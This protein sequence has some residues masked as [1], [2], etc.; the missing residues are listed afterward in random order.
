[1]LTIKVNFGDEDESGA[2]EM[3]AEPDG[4]DFVRSG[5]HDCLKT[6]VGELETELSTSQVVIGDLLHECDKPRQLHTGSQPG[7]ASTNDSDTWYDTYERIADQMDATG[8]AT[9]YP[10]ID[11][12][13]S[14]SPEKPSFSS[15]VDTSVDN[16]LVLV[17]PK[18]HKSYNALRLPSAKLGDNGSE[19]A[20]VSRRVLSVN[21][22]ARTAAP[23]D[24]VQTTT[25]GTEISLGSVVGDFLLMVWTMM[26]M[27]ITFFSG[28]F[29]GGLERVVGAARHFQAI[30]RRAGYYYI[31][32]WNE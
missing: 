20:P 23:V 4:S 7:L 32:F 26:T 21:A 5:A 29:V 8:Y 25:V 22:V 1:M 31:F 11:T 10:T 28:A 2:L 12:P 24:E 19:A 27:M 6:K 17:L 16:E 15:P 3:L 14:P 13:I 9:K 30:V 18:R